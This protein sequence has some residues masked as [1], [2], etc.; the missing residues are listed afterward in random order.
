MAASDGDG[1]VMQ[2]PVEEDLLIRRLD[3]RRI[4]PAEA[5]SVRRAVSARR[6]VAA[7]V[8]G[9]KVLVLLLSVRC[10]CRRVARRILEPA[11]LSGVAETVS[12]RW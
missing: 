6:P 1:R 7:P 4:V 8:L 9:R 10:S 3:G 11:G 12:C 5:S 2:Q